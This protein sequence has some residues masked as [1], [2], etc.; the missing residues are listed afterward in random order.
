MRKMFAL[1]AV[2][3]LLALAAVAYGSPPTKQTTKIQKTEKITI[4]KTVTADASAV[5]S[6]DAE[7]RTV[8]AV[9]VNYM[10]TA[11]VVGVAKTDN[12][13]VINRH[14]ASP[15]ERLSLGNAESRATMTYEWA[16]LLAYILNN[17]FCST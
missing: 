11:P 7:A 16:S 1:L 17:G 10:Q 2:F 12:T 15:P 5:A 8:E 6:R 13:T 3:A 9:A 14:S 4:I